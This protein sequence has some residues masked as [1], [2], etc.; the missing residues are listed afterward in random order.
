MT[1]CAPHTRLPAMLLAALAVTAF[2]GLLTAQRSLGARR[3]AGIARARHHRHRAGL[4]RLAGQCPDA[5]TP[6]SAAPAAALRAAVLCLINGERR[7]FGLPP[8][9]A[10]AG[11]DRMAQSWSTFMVAH[12][13]YDH[14]AFVARLGAF[15]YH[16]R[17]A[18]ENI[19]TGY[20]TPRGVVLAWMSSQEHC[21]NIL[22]PVFRDVGV[23][24]VPGYVP[25]AAN[26]GSTWTLDLGLRASEPPASGNTGPQSGCPY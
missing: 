4:G 16:W 12:D 7:R 13:E 14:A 10:N 24:V 17:T 6:A 2:C 9:G 25:M 15:G 11:L 21:R 26:I 22:E 18:G 1:P 20:A 5:M 3:Q 23:G 8:L 19:A